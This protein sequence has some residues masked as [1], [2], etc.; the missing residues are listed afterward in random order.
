MSTSYLISKCYNIQ[1]LKYVDYHFSYTEVD[2]V[3]IAQD[4]VDMFKKEGFEII[5]VDTSGRHKQEASLFEEMLQVSNTIVRKLQN[6]MFYISLKYYTIKIIYF[7]NLITLYS[8]WT[9]Q[10]VKLVKGR[11]ELLKIKSILVL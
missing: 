8:L 3:V 9:Q 1:L 4:G 7:R 5:V 2:P 11:L 6:K 10:S